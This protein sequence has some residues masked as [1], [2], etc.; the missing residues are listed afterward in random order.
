D[1]FSVMADSIQQ[2]SVDGVI[3]AINRNC[4]TEKFDY[5]ILDR[6]IREQF[7]I[8]TMLL[9][10]DYLCAMGPLQTRVEAFVEMIGGK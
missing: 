10:T 8:P 9:E 4:E 5:P 7:K 3:F 6:K 2:Y 1:R